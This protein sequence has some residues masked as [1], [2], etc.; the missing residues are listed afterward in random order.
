MRERC[1]LGSNP[2]AWL[3]DAQMGNLFHILKETKGSSHDF[4]TMYHM[5]EEF[6]HKKL[7]GETPSKSLQ[8]TIQEKVSA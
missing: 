5:P 1:I 2:T 4:R 3:N 8:K 6:F 7:T